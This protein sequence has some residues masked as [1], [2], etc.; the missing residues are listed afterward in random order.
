MLSLMTST[1][2]LADDEKDCWNQWFNNEYLFMCNADGRAGIDLKLII[3]YEA[4][5][6]LESEVD[7]KP[8]IRLFWGIAGFVGGVLVAKAID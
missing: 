6:E 8:A 1:S 4:I 3:G 2:V 7:K 5:K